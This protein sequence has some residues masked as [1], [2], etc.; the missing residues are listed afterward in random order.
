MKEVDRQIAED[1][2]VLMAEVLPDDRD[3]QHMAADEEASGGK[4]EPAVEALVEV[5]AIPSSESAS[6]V[7]AVAAG[8]FEGISD[9]QQI[10]SVAGGS[11]DHEAV[12]LSPTSA[13]RLRVMAR[14]KGRAAPR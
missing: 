8:E 12:A 5:E 7:D 10:V 6:D 1:E 14:P 11:S 9:G 3:W 13:P 4:T 2:A